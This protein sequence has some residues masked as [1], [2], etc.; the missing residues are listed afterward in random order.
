VLRS[1]SALLCLPQLWPTPDG[2]TPVRQHRIHMHHAVHRA[3]YLSATALAPATAM[4]PTAPALKS[5]DDSEGLS[6]DA[7]QCNRGCIDH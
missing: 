6:R 3:V 5:D 4:R 1:R 7:D 2:V